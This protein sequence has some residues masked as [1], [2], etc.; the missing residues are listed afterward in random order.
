MK[1]ICIVFGWYK[2]GYDTFI[3][4]SNKNINFFDEIYGFEAIQ[5]YNMIEEKKQLIDK[6]NLHNLKIELQNKAIWINNDG[7]MI[8]NLGKGSSSIYKEKKTGKLIN[9]FYCESI[10]INDFLL[11]FNKND[12]ELYVSMNLEGA[13]FEILDY[14]F[15]KNTFDKINVKE[16][17][18]DNHSNIAGRELE[19][20][21]TIKTNHNK[22]MTYFKRYSSRPFSGNP[23]DFLYSN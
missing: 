10:D 5:E 12:T 23:E 6:Y 1:R 3:K 8:Y 19:L 2:N 18:V 13:E 21:N 7:I 14:M 9:S 17:Y 20:K 22:L 15:L 16:F 4:V 11:Q